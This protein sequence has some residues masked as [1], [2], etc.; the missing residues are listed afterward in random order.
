MNQ[1]CPWSLC[2]LFTTA[3]WSS[4]RSDGLGKDWK[5]SVVSKQWGRYR[6]F[7]IS[8]VGTGARGFYAFFLCCF[9]LCAAE[10]RLML[11]FQFLIRSNVVLFDLFPGLC[12]CCVCFESIWE[13]ECRGGGSTPGV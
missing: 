10:G 13:V 6:D 8:Q 3:V 4:N 5:W 1:S 9:C 7:E 12:G 2:V 11:P